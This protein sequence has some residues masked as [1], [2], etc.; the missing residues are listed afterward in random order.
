MTF[1]VS[2]NSDAN[3][4]GIILIFHLRYDSYLHLEINR[5]IIKIIEGC[6]AVVQPVV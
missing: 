4:H 6:I 3:S 5:I 2:Y 1:P